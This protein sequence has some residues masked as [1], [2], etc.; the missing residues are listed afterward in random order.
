MEKYNNLMLLEVERN[1]QNEE[2]NMLEEEVELLQEK[3]YIQLNQM[4]ILM[5]TIT[6]TYKN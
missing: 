1:T 3:G 5:L 2:S 6:K 4:N